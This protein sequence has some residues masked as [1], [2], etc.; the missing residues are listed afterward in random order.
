MIV[1]IYL[2]KFFWFK[3]I[4]NNKIYT[5]AGTYIVADDNVLVMGKLFI[6]TMWLSK[7][8]QNYLDAIFYREKI[9]YWD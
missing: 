6:I 1:K 3:Y 8:K 2:K 9:D 5:E 7:Y 4:L